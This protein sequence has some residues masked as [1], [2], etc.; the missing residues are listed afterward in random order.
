MPSVGCRVHS[1][2]QAGAV[3]RLIV[4]RAASLAGVPSGVGTIYDNDTQLEFV[5][6]VE[7]LT[8]SPGSATVVLRGDLYNVAAPAG[9]PSP[10]T[11][12][13]VIAG[14]TG[15]D[16]GSVGIILSGEDGSITSVV[17]ERSDF[18]EITP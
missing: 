8:V 2:D 4:L 11:A 18:V 1:V 5:G 7:F 12:T 16:G 3:A 14:Q 6:A 10:A 17:P 15:V 13:V 9:A